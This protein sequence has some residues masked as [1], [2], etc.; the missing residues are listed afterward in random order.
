MALFEC[1]RLGLTEK[2]ENYKL[3]FFN[4]NGFLQPKRFSLFLYFFSP[5]LK[6]MISRTAN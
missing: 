4:L 5:V 2:N 1:R 3:I 6:A